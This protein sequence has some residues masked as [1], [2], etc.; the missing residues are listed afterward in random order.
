VVARAATI[1]GRDDVMAGV[2]A[3]VESIEIDALFPSGTA[4]VVVEQPFGPGAAGSAP[5]EVIP[6]ADPVTVNAGREVHSVLVENLSDVPVEVT[7][8]SHFFEANRCL[9]FDRR[10]AFGMRL[11]T[12]AG[13]SVRW[14][15]GE[16]KEVGLIPIGGN[17]EVWGFGGLVDG[18]LSGVDAAAVLD[19][20][21]RRGYR[22]EEAPG[23]D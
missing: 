1:L 14:E 10:A 19:E 20:A 3:I 16:R 2:P 11:D 21:I 18:P 4:L 12:P 6:A 15:P 5:G 7:S 9:G 17:Q 13:V 22:H 8:H 23:A